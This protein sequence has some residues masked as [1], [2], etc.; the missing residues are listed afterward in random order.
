MK[1]SGFFIVLAALMTHLHVDAAPL[2]C[3]MQSMLANVTAIARDQGKSPSQVRATLQKSGD[4]TNSEI[5]AL[6]DIAFVHM[7]NSSPQEISQAVL[8]VCKG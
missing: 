8:L 3:Q 7:K 4:L 1:A 2:S 5:K 6:I